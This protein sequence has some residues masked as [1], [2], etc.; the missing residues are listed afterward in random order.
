MKKIILLILFLGVGFVFLWYGNYSSAIRY[1]LDPSSSDRV[2][3]DIKEGATG[4]DIARRLLEKNLISSPSAFRFYVKQQELGSQLKAGRMVF[5]ENMTLPEI[6]KVLVEGKSEEFAVTLLEGW[7]AKQIAEKLEAAG[8]TT[9]DDFLACLEGCEFDFNFIPEDYLEG[10]LYPDTYFVNPASYSDERFIDRLITTLK[11]KISKEDW[12]VINASGRDF[13]DIMIMASIV[14]REE[15]NE[16]ERATVAGI[17]WNR[18][19]AGIGLGADATVLYA[20][21]RTSGGLTR[22]D[23]DVDS[24]YNTRKYRD[25][26]P[27]PI[28][29]PSISS[30]R[31]ALYPESTDYWYYLHDSDGVVHYG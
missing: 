7:T 4:D 11:N 17:L 21:G 28:C 13:E 23:L 25:L 19:D 29:S 22:E 15:R 14:E 30:I 1:S 9:T 3:V 24:P 27:T 10:Y 2:T 5:Q 20:L 16:S 26:P 8:L 18:Y 31:A 12:E 6:V